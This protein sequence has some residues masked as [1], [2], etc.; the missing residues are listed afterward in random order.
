MLRDYFGDAETVTLLVIDAARVVPEIKYEVS[1]T[2]GED[3]P[4]IYG[5]LDVSTVV[6]TIDITRDTPTWTVAVD[7]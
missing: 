5:P 1:P 6:E 7:L 2:T 4:H 3:Y